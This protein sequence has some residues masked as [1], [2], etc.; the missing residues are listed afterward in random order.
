MLAE[1]APL[2]RSERHLC[3]SAVVRQPAVIGD[4]NCSA[5]LICFVLRVGNE[6]SINE[7]LYA[8]KQG[9]L[10]GITEPRVFARAASARKVPQEGLKYLPIR[11]R[12]T[13]G[14]GGVNPLC[15]LPQV[16][17]EAPVPLLPAQRAQ[18]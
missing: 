4:R 3:T 1:A 16:F 18:L 10:R 11:G 8:V 2:D 12:Y 9:R 14:V 13:F 7:L 5:P 6:M 17:V 15:F